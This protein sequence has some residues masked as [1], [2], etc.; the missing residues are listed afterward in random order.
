MVKFM[1]DTPSIFSVSPYSSSVAREMYPG[2]LGQDDQQDA[3][4]HMLASGTL[5]RKYGPNVAQLLG[6]AHEWS[7][8]PL[9][10]LMMMIGQRQPTPEYLMDT[11][12][13]ALG[14]Q[15][16]ARAQTQSELEDL[17]Q[18]EAERAQLNAPTGRAV[19]R[20]AQGGAVRSPLNYVKECSCHG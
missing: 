18:S 20:K 10:A 3:A 1:S 12:N 19:I 5:A 9:Q 7:V 15:L 11:R 4:R 13:N 2:Q 14:A 17:V 6:K 8:S 16:G